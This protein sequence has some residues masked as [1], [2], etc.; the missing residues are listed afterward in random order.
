MTR[1]IVVL[2]VV[3]GMAAGRGA[4]AQRTGGS[5]LTVKVVGFRNAKGRVDVL[6]FNNARGFPDQKP[7]SLDVGE[8]PVDRL[9][10]T[11][12]VVFRNLPP[13]LYAVSVLHD[14]N[15]NR[16]LDSNLLGIPREGYGA[17]MNPPKMRRAPT[18][19]EAKFSLA[20][21]GRAIQIRLIYY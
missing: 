15:M 13:G 6:L 1:R 4:V 5:V 14:E 20:P 7:K 16:K 12:E 11:A 21:G 8:V 19:D 10:L 9:S 2:L 3:L 18:F 17:S